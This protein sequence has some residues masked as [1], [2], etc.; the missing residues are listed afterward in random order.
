MRCMLS[1]NADAFYV[2]NVLSK[3]HTSFSVITM[4]M[5]CVFKS[6]LSVN[7]R[8][9][10]GEHK[11]EGEAKRRRKNECR[12]LGLAGHQLQCNTETCLI[13]FVF[14]EGSNSCYA[15]D[16]IMHASRSLLLLLLLGRGWLGACRGTRTSHG[17][18]SGRTSPRGPPG[19]G[20]TPTPDLPPKRRRR[21]AGKGAGIRHRLQCVTKLGRRGGIGHVGRRRRRRK[22][23]HSR[24]RRWD[25]LDM[26][27]TGALCRSHR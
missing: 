7:E 15:R 23:T 21:R 3:M 25:T 16:N 17:L 9:L 26:R 22:G 11:G 27:Q 6:L 19:P 4:V 18:T 10:D 14:C 12:G 24:R 1:Y 13:N 2:V 5:M 8:S 20:T